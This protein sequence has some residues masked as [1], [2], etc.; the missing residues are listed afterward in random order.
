VVPGEIDRIRLAWPDTGAAEA[1]VVA[2]VLESGMLTQGPV[3]AEFERE[4]ARA[5]ET[6]HA[7]AVSS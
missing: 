1:A 5:C 4:L 7:L 2:E 6:T 3:L